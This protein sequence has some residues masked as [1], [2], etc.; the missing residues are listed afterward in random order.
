[1]NLFCYFLYNQKTRKTA[2]EA[3]DFATLAMDKE[4]KTKVNDIYYVPIH[5]DI[6]QQH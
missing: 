3:F 5:Q 6:I 1:M 4:D 2:D